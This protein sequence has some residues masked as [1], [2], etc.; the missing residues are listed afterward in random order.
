MRSIQASCYITIMPPRLF[1]M[2]EEIEISEGRDAKFFEDDGVVS[3]YVYED[4][5]ASAVTFTKEDL[6]KM[7][8]L[9][10]GQE[11]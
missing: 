2:G 9:F 3:V 11:A 6:E 10:D 4:L 7:L 1:L 5:G 8:G